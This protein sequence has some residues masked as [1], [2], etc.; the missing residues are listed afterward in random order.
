LCVC[1]CC[2]VFL[3]IMCIYNIIIYQIR[4]ATSRHRAFLHRTFGLRN[5]QVVILSGMVRCVDF[6]SISGSLGGHFGV[7]GLHFGGFWNS[8][9][10]LW[11]P[12]GA[13]WRGG[14][15]WRRPCQEIPP[16]F[17]ISFGTKNLK[18]RN[19]AQKRSVQKAVK[20][21]CGPRTVPKRQNV[22]FI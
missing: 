6:T 12:L 20:K 13:F 3:V 10:E 16:R 7:L 19:K 5:F 21:K 1:F 11:T 2:V 17:G 15:F 4:C 9:A 14:P 8:G 22:D 18:S